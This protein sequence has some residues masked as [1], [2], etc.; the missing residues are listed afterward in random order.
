[1]KSLDGE[2][3]ICSQIDL[4]DIWREV[5]LDKLFVSGDSG[6]VMPHPS[7]SWASDF[8]DT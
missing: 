6:E 8:T 4:K 7:G 3:V 1:M 5:F 2:E